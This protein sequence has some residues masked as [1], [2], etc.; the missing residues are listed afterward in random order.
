MS[1]RLVVSIF[2]IFMIDLNRK[3][4]IKK[5]RIDRKI[6]QKKIDVLIE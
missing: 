5:N 1:G 6:A 4:P 2:Q 3:S